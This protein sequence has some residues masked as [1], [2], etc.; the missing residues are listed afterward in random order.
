[1]KKINYLIK[2]MFFCGA[3]FL[4]SCETTE[5]DLTE[6]PNALTP[7]QANPDFFMNSIQTKFVRIVETFGSRGAELTRMDYMSGRDYTSAYSP[8]GFSGVW[9]TAYSGM[10]ED[11]RLMNVLAE[12]SGLTHHI[13]MGQVFQAYTLLTLVDSFGDVPYTEALLGNENLNPLADSGESVYA[14]AIGLLDAAIANFNGDAAGDPALD[15]YYGK[16]WS[17]WIKA[18]NTIKMKAYLATR[19]V[20]ASAVSKFNA[21]VASGDYISD[22]AD[23]FQFKWGSNELQPDTRHP[24]YSG[25]YT[26]TGGGNYM[27]NSLMDYMTGKN[28]GAYSNPLNFDIRTLFYFYRQVSASPGQAGA[29]ANEETLECSLYTAPLHYTG[30]TYCAVPKGWWGRDH[31]NNN[32]IPPDGFLRALAGV[33]PAGG[34]L[35]DLSYKSKKNGDGNKGAGITPIM[36]ASWTKFMIAETQMISGA[37]ASAKTTMFEGINM[38]IDKV[39]NFAPVNDRFNWIFGTAD[40]GPAIALADDYIEWFNL[41]LAADW[42]AGDGEDKMNI[43]AMQY[44]VASY[45]NGIDAYN[46]YRR[47]GYPT[48]LQPNIEPNPG[49]F[50]RSF[51]YPANYANTNVNATQKNGV[52]VQVFW[53]TNPAS[54]G[55]PSAN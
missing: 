43:L 10:M 28:A 54:P 4:G 55:F 38:S 53:D 16:N 22:T 26:P 24:S 18:A 44:F 1:M 47:T 42:D 40:G 35:D 25:S 46:F 29:P 17:K 34:S 15:L 30:Y 5:L 51:W 41:D 48:T 52:G 8:A 9:S 37:T 19:L 32:G 33:Y 23:D 21:I 3:L 50:I 7:S 27:S 39:V 31:G 11:I 36:L 12:E 20:D 14:A 49:G 2:L 6:N 13:G 45:G